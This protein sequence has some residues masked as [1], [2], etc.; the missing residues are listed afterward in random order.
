MIDI[1]TVVFREELPILRL[2]AESIELYCQNMMLGNII[3]IV[4]DDSMSEDDIDPAW[5]GSMAGQVKIVHRCKLS[6]SWVNDGW[7][8]QQLCKLLASADVKSSTW[9]MVLD[10]KTIL[11]QPV[12][13]NRLFD[14]Q[15][16]L[17]WGY[18]QIITVF[19]PAKK[20]VSK[21]FNID[22]QHAAGPAGVPFF[23]NN[24]IVRSMI[25][26]VET[27]TN[28]LF[29]NW[30]QETGMVTE[31]ILYTG[32]VQYQDGSLDKAYSKIFRNQ[33]HICNVCHSEVG[34]FDSKFLQMQHPD[35]LTVSVH[36]NAWTKLTD[37]Q[38]QA[39]CN[40]LLISGITCAKDLI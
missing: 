10:A 25:T 34:I 32:Y 39:Y 8:T 11:I 15:G 9:T 19:E 6:D 22:L 21:L 1:V 27:Q 30:F 5:Y 2:Q 38:K 16:R 37:L 20:I 7:L 17:T 4:N 24:D 12:D 36:R 23:F 31:F 14:E 3:I 13:L 40:L 18:S 29:A 33:Y 26:R 35:T 28:K